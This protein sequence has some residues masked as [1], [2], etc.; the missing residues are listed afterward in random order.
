M[1]VV[2]VQIYSDQYTPWDRSKIDFPINIENT[3]E[4][5]EVLSVDNKIEGREIFALVDLL[6]AKEL[7]I[8]KF[9]GLEGSTFSLILNYLI[10]CK[11][12]IILK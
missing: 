12:S 5:S 9:I 3:N 8:D 6:T 7:T 2:S 11:K 1:N 4:K 10:E